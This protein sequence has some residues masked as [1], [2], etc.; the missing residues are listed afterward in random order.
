MRC[1]R[2]YCLLGC[3]AAQLGSGV[4]QSMNPKLVYPMTPGIPLTPN[5]A[6]AFAVSM[7]GIV[8][9][10]FSHNV[11]LKR[12]VLPITLLVFHVL[13]F[14]VI[15]RSGGLFHLPASALAALLALNALYVF[16]VVGYCSTCGRSVQRSLIRGASVRC[17]S[18][19]LA[20]GR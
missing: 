17:S 4:S 15:E 14:I 3:A 18:C 19:T 1:W 16:R 13:V 20:N 6:V 10:L 12:V 5:L 7:G 9:M 2:A 8:T 11:R